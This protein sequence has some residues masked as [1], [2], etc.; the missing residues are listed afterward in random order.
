MQVELLRVEDV[1][2][3]TNQG[4]VC[5]PFFPLSTMPEFQSF[6]ASV[7]VQ[8]PGAPSFVVEASF[9]V[10]HFKILDI[11]APAEKRWQI[12]TCFGKIPKGVVPL[13]SVLLCD[14]VVREKLRT[15][16]TMSPRN[17]QHQ[18]AKI[19]LFEPKL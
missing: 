1:F 16:R 7:T 19:G 6:K 10:T 5:A 2:D 11:S 8:P 15:G 14:E 12:V 3:L 9:D 4:L 13:G 18:S 17:E